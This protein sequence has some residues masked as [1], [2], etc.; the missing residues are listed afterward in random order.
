MSSSAYRSKKKQAWV[1]P[2]ETNVMDKITGDKSFK[3]LA[4]GESMGISKRKRA[5][6]KLPRVPKP[7]PAA[8]FYYS[9][10]PKSFVR[11]LS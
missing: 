2:P 1:K 5:R 3:K 4:G 8:P 9:F 11:K 6:D 7:P 10:C